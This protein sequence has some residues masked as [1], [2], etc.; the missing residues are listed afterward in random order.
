M[1]ARFKVEV[2]GDK[3]PKTS[4]TL[5][6]TT[7][8]TNPYENERARKAEEKKQQ[9]DAEKAEQQQAERSKQPV[10]LRAG[11]GK[12]MASPVAAP[13]AS[14]SAAAASAASAFGTALTSSAAAAAAEGEGEPRKKRV[15][16]G[17]FGDFSGW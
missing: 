5:L 8:F 6:G 1:L 10:A 2:D 13:S 12:Y 9:E 17:S 14:S 7:I 16:T 4:V 3:R 11:V 15:K